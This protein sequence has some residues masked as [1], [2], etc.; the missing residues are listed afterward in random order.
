MKTG[1]T[2]CT[3][4]IGSK[5]IT[6]LQSGDWPDLSLSGGTVRNASAA[7]ADPG[8]FVTDRPEELFQRS[9][10]I[11]DFTSPEATARH[12]ELAAEQGV[13]LVAATSGLSTAQEESLARAAQKTP[14]V[15]AAN[16]SI[17][18]NVLLGLI[19]KAAVQ[20]NDGWDAEIIDIHHRYKKDAPSGTSYALAKAVQKGRGHETPLTFERKGMTGPREKGSIGFS[21]QRGGDSTIENSVIFFGDGERLELTHRA[22]DRAIFAKGAIEAA[23]WARDQKPGLYTMRDVL[24]I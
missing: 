5:L 9:D 14:I 11:I 24:Q 12:A 2:G 19:E 13:I 3:G 6:E 18:I 7:P 23:L 16:T 20:L 15:Y 21:V 17:G 4:R 1:I 22:M 10:A 8:F